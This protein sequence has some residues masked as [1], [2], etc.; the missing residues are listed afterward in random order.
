MSDIDVVR[1]EECE[2]GAE[3][4]ASE[5]KILLD[6]GWRDARLDPPENERL[7]QVAWDDGSTGPNAFC[8]YDSKAETPGDGKRFWWTMTIEPLPDGHVLARRELA[9]NAI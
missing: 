7:V 3:A 8:F 4:G 2:S 1:A 9:S 5:L 6:A